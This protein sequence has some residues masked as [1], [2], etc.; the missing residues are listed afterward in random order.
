MNEDMAE[1]T[2]VDL[3]CRTT[4]TF[5]EESEVHLKHHDPHKNSIISF[6]ITLNVYFPRMRLLLNASTGDTW[7]WLKR[8]LPQMVLLSCN[9]AQKR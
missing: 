4:G 9:T 3:S 8:R 7:A 6:R 1:N 5:S 2:V